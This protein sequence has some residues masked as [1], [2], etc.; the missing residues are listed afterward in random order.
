MIN[1]IILF[2]VLSFIK[3][4]SC[5]SPFQKEVDWFII[6]LIPK[7]SSNNEFKYVY[8]DNIEKEFKDYNVD[9]NFP[10]TYLTYNLNKDNSNYITWNDDAKNGNENVIYNESVAHSKGVLSFGERRGFYL[11]HSLP[12]FPF[13]NNEIILNE[14]P[15]N[16]GFF[17]QTFFC[18]SV[19][20]GTVMKILDS[21]FLI[22]PQIL[23]HRVITNKI[24]MYNKI[25]K[26]VKRDFRNRNSET[27]FSIV[28]IGGLKVDIF[29]K[30]EIDELPW[31]GLIPK[32][33]DDDFYVETWVKPILLPNIC[34]K[35]ETINIIDLD[36]LNYKF[37][38]SDDHSKWAISKKKK[39]LCY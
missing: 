35:K 33:Y 29:L 6:Y 18:M 38:N 9:E 13:H 34:D 11:I 12:R 30:K 20:L 17:G 5:F 26:L 28:S 25:E 21:L 2:I 10:P 22:E 24:L 32:F 39:I 27:T 7:N 36:I 19:N 37:K 4:E 31:D 3:S 8:I 1:I 16:A 23:L 14:L 15:S